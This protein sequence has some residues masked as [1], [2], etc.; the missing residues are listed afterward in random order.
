MHRNILWWGQT[1]PSGAQPQDKWQR[2]TKGSTGYSICLWGKASLRVTETGAGCPERLWSPFSQDAQNPPVSPARGWPSLGRGWT[3]CSPEAP[4]NLNNPLIFIWYNTDSLIWKYRKRHC[5]QP[6]VTSPRTPF[7]HTSTCIKE[8]LV[9]ERC[10][11]SP[12]NKP[13]V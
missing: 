5:R 9:T 2:G 12:L 6:M 13:Y 7:H 1:L 11:N 4:S 8:G 3:R 10:K